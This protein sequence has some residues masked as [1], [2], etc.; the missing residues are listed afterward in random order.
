MNLKGVGE[1]VPPSM[2]VCPYCRKPF[3][4]LKSHL[5]HCKV[6]RGAVPAHQEVG[7]SNS[8]Q[9]VGP[10]KPAALPR[11]RAIKGPIRDSVKAKEKGLGT[12]SKARNPALKEDKSKRTVKPSPPL[13]VGLG[14]A[15]N[16]KA[17]KDIKSQIQSSIEMLKNTEPKIAFLGETTAQFSASENTTPKKELA[18]DL[19]KSGE[20][21]NN[22]SETEASL[23]LGPMGPSLSDQDRKYSSA[24]PNDIQAT[25]AD[26]RLD[27]MDAP[28]Q[29]LLIKFLDMRLGD[30]HSSP[31]SL[32]YGVKR[33]NMSNRV[34]MSSSS[35]E[36]D[37]KAKDHLLASTD[38]RD[39]KTREK[40]TESQIAAFEF[41]P[42]GK[43]QVKENHS[44]GLDLGAEACGSQGNSEKSAFVTEMQEWAALGDD[45]VTERTSR[46]EGPDL[47]LL[48]PVGAT[49]S[50]LLAVSQSRNQSLT[51]LAIKFLQEE[52]AEACSHDRVPAVKALMEGEERAPLTPKSGCHRP[53]SHPGGRLSARAS[54]Q[55]APQSPFTRQVGTAERKTLSSALGLE[56]FPELYPGYLGLG[57]LPGKPRHWGAL[58]QKP[59]FVSPWEEGVSQVPLLERSSTAVR[60]LE[61]PASLTTSSLSLRRLL[62]AVQTGWIR[63]RTTMRSGVGSITMLFMGCFV[64]CGSWSFKHLKMQRWRKQC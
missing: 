28:R 1:V 44:K 60:S 35:S 64:L 29:N 38:L 8:H 9:E 62:G 19:S 21:R 2:E 4:R 26:L 27:R 40:N 37:S 20:S 18:N 22:P 34:S 57:V 46:G 45:S 63:C 61:A 15:S 33:L 53:A 24:F 56:W 6:T 12:D 58:A 11:A 31:T 48:M 36:R 10:S 52:K 54:L 17:N 7:P 49:C 41:S 55:H 3:K 59:M 43:I 14:K 23:P 42:V 25:P 51:P 30:D 13:A 32:T 39:L 50:E 5:P 47:N 16:T